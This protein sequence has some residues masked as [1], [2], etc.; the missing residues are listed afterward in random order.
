[1]FKEP[2]ASGESPLQPKTS[3]HKTAQQKTA[4][5]NFVPYE[6]FIHE[7]Y[8]KTRAETV[9]LHKSCDYLPGGRLAHLPTPTL[10]HSEEA[11]LNY[12]NPSPAVHHP[13]D[14]IAPP[15]RFTDPSGEL[16]SYSSNNAR[17]LMY[18]ARYGL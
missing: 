3:Q 17:A 13:H 14:D 7:S 2:H 16:G 8:G 9:M 12:F 10:F 18:A 4:S 1:M 5:K 11:A 6:I 15:D